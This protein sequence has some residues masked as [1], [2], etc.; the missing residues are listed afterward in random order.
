MLSQHEIIT[1]FPHVSREEKKT[2]H[3]T[4]PRSRRDRFSR[5]R[6]SQ[7]LIAPSR[8][9]RGFYS[10]ALLF[11]PV[12]LLLAIVSFT[13]VICLTPVYTNSS[14]LRVQQPIC[15]TASAQVPLFTAYG[16]LLTLA[17]QV[18]RGML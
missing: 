1:D 15:H 7:S 12:V 5:F 17:M 9:P 16:L 18:S 6:A 13:F 14:I 8:A 4:M 2:Q 3:I 11:A 10:T